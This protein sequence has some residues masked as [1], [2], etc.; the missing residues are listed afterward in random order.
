MPFFLFAFP[1]N[2][3][4][5]SYKLDDGSFFRYENN[6][7]FFIFSLGLCMLNLTTCQGE[8]ENSNEGDIYDKWL[9]VWPEAEMNFKQLLFSVLIYLD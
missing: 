1:W 2:D 7:F 6:V 8:S 9:E 4:F 3:F 5:V